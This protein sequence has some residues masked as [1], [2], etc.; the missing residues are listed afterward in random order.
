VVVAA[1]VVAAAV[2]AVAVVVAAAALRPLEGRAS[3]RR[4]S[5]TQTPCSRRSGPGEKQNGAGE[6]YG[7]APHGPPQKQAS[8][9]KLGSVVS[10][11][12]MSN[13]VTRAAVG[14]LR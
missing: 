9:Y 5:P 10:I 7:Y 2:A 12:E 8:A 11:C 4:T 3:C 13:G 14:A 1:A 6:S